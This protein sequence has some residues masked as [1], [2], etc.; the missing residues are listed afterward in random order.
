VAN[1]TSYSN[2]SF[3]NTNDLRNEIDKGPLVVGIHVND[4]G[5]YFYNNGIYE[6]TSTC[7]VKLPNSNLPD[8]NH[9]LLAVGYGLL[10]TGNVKYFILLNSWGLDWGINGYVYFTPGKCNLGAHASRPVGL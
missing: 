5:F 3:L 2:W 10:N 9:Y 8:V 4:N 7:D 6:P 1:I